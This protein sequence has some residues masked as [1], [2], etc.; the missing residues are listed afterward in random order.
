[1]FAEQD[2]ELCEIEATVNTGFEEMAMEEVAEKFG[3]VSTMA[4]GKINFCMPIRDA[5]KVTVPCG[6]FSWCW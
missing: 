6:L 5:R 4:R 2:L 3:I 1:M